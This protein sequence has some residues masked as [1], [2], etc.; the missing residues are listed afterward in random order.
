MFAP[1]AD[2]PH[3]WIATALAALVLTGMALQLPR[4]SPSRAGAVTETI[5]A[6]AGSPYPTTARHQLD[7]AAVRIS[8]RRFSLRTTWGVSHATVRYAPVTPVPAGGRLSKLLYGAAPSTVFDSLTDF[9]SAVE[10]AR[11]ST[12]NWREADG[13]LLVRKV[14]WEG[15]RVTL[16]GQ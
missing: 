6:V 10:T 8:P 2:T 3:I 13:P 16:V 4:T 9:R 15:T 14:I 12:V 5:D 7:A 11:N 1:P